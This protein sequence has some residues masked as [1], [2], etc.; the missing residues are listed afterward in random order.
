MSFKVYR[1]SAGSG[2]TYTLVLEYLKIALGNSPHAYRQI[3]A[4]TFT[5]KAASEMKERVLQALR[6]FS[7]VREDGSTTHLFESLKTELEVSNETLRQRSKVVL[8]DILH[9]Y[10]DFSIGTIDK[11]THKIV[12]T[13]AHDLK[14]NVGFDVELDEKNLLQR[15]VDQLI[16]KAGTDEGLTNLLIDFILRKM[17][18]NRNWQVEQDLLKFSSIIM[19]EDSPARLQDLKDVSTA[20][21]FAIRKELARRINLFASSVKQMGEKALATL[22]EH[23]ID[24]ASL[25]GGTNGI[26]KY[27]SYL[28]QTRMDKLTPTA[29]VQKY[30]Q[31]DKWCA[32]KVSADQKQLIDSIAERLKEI[33]TEAT[34]LVEENFPKISL[35][36][37]IEKNIFSLALLNRIEQELDAV[38]NEYNVLPISDFN[39][40]ISEVVMEEP[41]PFIYERIGERYHH[42]LIDEFQDTSLLQWQNLLP[43]IENALGGGHFNMLVGDAKQAIYR[44]RG[45]EVEQFVKL[46]GIHKPLNEE[47][48]V[49]K[50]QSLQYHYKEE[51]LKNNFRSKME[52][53]D[54]NNSFF[55]SLHTLMSDY[56]IAIYGDIAQ[57]FDPEN[58][59]GGVGIHVLE[60]AGDKDYETLICENVLEI[61]LKS[62]EQKYEFDDIAV[63]CKKNGEGSLIAQYLIEHGIPVVSSESLLLISSAEVRLVLHIIRLL[64][65]PDNRFLAAKIIEFLIQSGRGQGDVYEVTNHFI[66]SSEGIFEYI[67]RFGIHLDASILELLP[68][69]DLT[70]TIMRSF[71]W[72]EKANPYLQS[73]LDVI[74]QYS[75][76]EGN[77]RIGFLDWWSQKSTKFSIQVPEGTRAVNVMTV[78]KSKGLE[79]PVVIHPFATYTARIQRSNAWV[80][81]SDENISPLQSALVPVNKQ[82]ENTR[83]KEVFQEEQEKSL[84]DMLNVLYVALTR[85][86]EKLYILTEPPSK[87]R[88]NRSASDLL[89]YYYEQTDAYRENKQWMVFG[90]LEVMNSG[91]SNKKGKNEMVMTQFVSNDWKERITVTYRS[92]KLWE[93]GDHLQA[94]D[95]GNL[96]HDVL[97]GVRTI[98]DVSPQMD[99]LLLTGMITSE[100]CEEITENIL[101]VLQKEEIK[102]FY[103]EG[104]QVINEVDILLP[105]GKGYRPD[106]VVLSGNTVVVID[107]KTGLEDQGHFNQL[108]AYKKVLSEMGYEEVKAFLVYLG[109]EEKIVSVN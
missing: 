108:M 67:S 75:N 99:K 17:E 79:F 64:S 78:H 32:G 15:S 11:F 27:F 22:S 97:S 105:E 101:N 4:I 102:Q 34:R 82:L 92:S 89:A 38:K 70:E 14:I 87:N 94:R 71:G 81:V 25:A 48:A 3:L 18:D 107:Y 76:K 51:L 58:T 52:V 57:R 63:L 40:K 86:R 6:E 47:F 43:L 42:F 16:T 23:G 104:L 29:T 28:A 26:A 85:P 61:V 20:D 13:F 91:G 54:F 10:A 53:V 9:N 8:T 68:L 12:R 46:P 88:S 5:N 45:G 93:K 90:N 56:G 49:Q 60:E 24:P 7:E 1:S 106:R 33:Y 36:A 55:S 74:F 37:L 21:F 103:K 44:W 35:L 2:K 65:D 95:Y 80:D 50:E 19:E 109:G 100:E 72:M 73:L 66:N 96:I 69:Y 62:K 39:K 83:F 77:E 59:G 30:I 98:D 41:I 84:L 31:E